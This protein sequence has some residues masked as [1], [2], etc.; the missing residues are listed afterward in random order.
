MPGPRNKPTGDDDIEAPLPSTPVPGGGQRIARS[1]HNIS[2]RNIDAD[3][4]KVLYRLYRAGHT[5][6]LVGGG[7]RDLLL[8]RRPKDFDIVTSARPAQVKRLFRNCRLIG[9]RFRL[10]HLHYPDGK[11]I[12]LSTFRANPDLEPRDG[13]EEGDLL[14]VSDNRFGTPRQDSERRDFTINSLFYD[15]AGFCLIDYVGGLEDIRGQVIRTIGE[16]MQRFQ[17]DPVRMVRA[18]KFSARLGFEIEPATWRAMTRLSSLIQRSAPARVSEELARL[19]DEGAAARSLELMDESGLLEAIDFHL[20]A[21]LRI[22]ERGELEY[23]HDGRLLYRLLKRCDLQRGMGKMSRPLLFCFWILPIALME[24]LLDSEDDEEGWSTVVFDS[25]ARL[26]FAR[27]EAEMMHL[28]LSL[29]RRLALRR[30]RKRGQG[31]PL[32]EREGF[33]EAL[34]LLEFFSAEVPAYAGE[35]D[36]WK[37]RHDERQPQRRPGAAVAAAR[38]RTGAPGIRKPVELDRGRRRLRRRQPNEEGGSDGI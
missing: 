16:P 36:Y 20:E 17:E 5:A 7:V 21:Y 37:Q 25:V 23:D 19:L 26:G 35:Y 34:R 13:D 22:A 32:E 15:I 6:Y 38:P 4:I 10:A 18:V 28:T 27:R 1:N 29:F 14:V 3:A 8:G 9:R 31:R 33:P 24:G 11:I 30:K 12:E 2:R